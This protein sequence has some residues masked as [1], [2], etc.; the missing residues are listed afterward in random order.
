MG[1]RKNRN[2]DRD[3]RPSP[4]RNDDPPEAFVTGRPDPPRP[5]KWFLLATAAVLS[6]WIVFLAVL[7][8]E[9]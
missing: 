9:S 6:A 8:V 4:A 2:K 3:K 1:R 7:A 5:N